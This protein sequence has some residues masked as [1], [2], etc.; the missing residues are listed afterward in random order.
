MNEMLT[1]L[2]IY[3]EFKNAPF[4]VSQTKVNCESA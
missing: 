3:I 2:G 1:C 4:E